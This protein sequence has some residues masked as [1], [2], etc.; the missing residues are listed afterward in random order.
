MKCG[1]DFYRLKD[2]ELESTPAKRFSGIAKRKFAKR[3][4]LPSRPEK[5]ARLAVR[6]L[7]QMR[8]VEFALNPAQQLEIVCGFF[9]LP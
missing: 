8:V 2:Q 3:Q 7:R 9:P 1:N 5:L 4:S 6:G